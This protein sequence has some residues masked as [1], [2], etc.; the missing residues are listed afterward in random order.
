MLTY[1]QYFMYNEIILNEIYIA[2]CEHTCAKNLAFK[3]MNCGYRS[4]GKPSIRL[5][6]QLLT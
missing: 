4:V 6:I 1:T 3:H 2:Y 5:L